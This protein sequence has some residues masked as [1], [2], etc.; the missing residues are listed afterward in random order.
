MI[1]GIIL[2]QNYSSKK[3]SENLFLIK[4]ASG[5]IQTVKVSDIAELRKEENPKYAPKF[6]LM[7]KDGEVVVN[8]NPATFV[9]V[10]ENDDLLVLDSIGKT[11]IMPD[12]GGKILVTVE[13]RLD[14]SKGMEAFQ[15]IKVTESKVKKQR[16]FCFSYKDLVNAVYHAKEIETSINKTTKAVYEL[17]STGVY[18]LYDAKGMRAIPFT[19]KRK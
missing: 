7:L 17:N 9:K 18:A 19:V 16:I 2:E 4:T 11:V 13:Y 15:L 5:A 10:V 3:D 6:D 14:N 1:K 12:N 8:R